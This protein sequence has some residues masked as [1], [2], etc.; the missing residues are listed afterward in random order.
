MRSVSLVV[1]CVPG[2]SHEEVA[3]SLCLAYCTAWFRLTRGCQLER[4]GGE[5]E[6]VREREDI[7]E[8][9]RERREGGGE[10]EGEIGMQGEEGERE[11]SWERGRRVGREGRDECT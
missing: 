3:G 11:K 2:H 7:R 4:E 9:G 10:G 1:R 8:V 6:G 5:R